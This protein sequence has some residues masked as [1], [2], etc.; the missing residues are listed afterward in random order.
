MLLSRVPDPAGLVMCEVVLHPADIVTAAK[1]QKN[2]EERNGG[3]SAFCKNSLEYIFGTLGRFRAHLDN[4]WFQDPLRSK[5]E[6]DDSLRKC[7]ATR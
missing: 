1:Y 5:R 3:R 4:L 6:D 2:D 7:A